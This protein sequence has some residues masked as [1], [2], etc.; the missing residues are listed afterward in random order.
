MLNY[1]H[2]DL[3]RLEKSLIIWLQ[4]IDVIDG[5]INKLSQISDK[6]SNGSALV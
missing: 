4:E 3:N 1:N 2:Q 5:S 6:W